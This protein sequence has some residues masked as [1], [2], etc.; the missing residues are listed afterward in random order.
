MRLAL[1][2]RN[3]NFGI[4]FLLIINAGMPLTTSAQRI[5]AGELH[6]LFLCYDHT[7]RSCG[8]GWCDQLGNGDT[9]GNDQYEPVPVINLTNIIAVSAKWYSSLFLRNDGTAWAVGSNP[10][11]ELGDGTNHW[12]VVP[13]KVANL[14]N[15]IGI[16]MSAH[17]LFLCDGGSVWA[18]GRNS[19]GQLGLGD[20]QNRNTPVDI[21]SLSNVWAISCGWYHSIFVKNDKTAWTSGDNSTYGQLG[22]GTMIQRNTPVQVLGLKG[23]I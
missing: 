21:S 17:S 4:A 1:P 3:F 7:A 12:R 11:G 23:I 18:C 6:S 19:E 8:A 13:T 22:D 2:R 5:A 14:N 20:L 16:S 10:Y 15:I 9:A